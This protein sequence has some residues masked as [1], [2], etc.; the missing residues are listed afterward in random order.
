MSSL[1]E[2]IAYLPEHLLYE[3]LMLRFTLMRLDMDQTQLLWNAL[4]EAFGVHARNLYD[5]L[6]NEKASRNFKADDFIDGFALNDRNA[7]HGLMQKMYEQ[8]LHLGKQR[9]ADKNEKIQL[10][11]VK[12]VAV[13]IEQGLNQFAIELPEPYKSKWKPNEADPANVPDA[14]YMLTGQP[15][16][17]S[18]F[19][20]TTR[21]PPGYTGYTGYTG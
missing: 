11:D 9:T 21:G 10:D 20:A 17:S 16:T 13:W 7:V 6:R 5:F 14:I 12:K 4:Y 8:I 19:A 2:R 1:E 3:V 18:M 15:S